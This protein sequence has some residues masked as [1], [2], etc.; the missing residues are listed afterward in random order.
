MGVYVGRMCCKCMACS[1]SCNKFQSE[2]WRKTAVVCQAAIMSETSFGKKKWHPGNRGMEGRSVHCSTPGP[3]GGRWDTASCSHIFLV[4]T[5]I[6]Q[7]SVLCLEASQPLCFP[8]FLIVGLGFFCVCGLAYSCPYFIKFERASS[9]HV[10]LRHKY[11][12][13]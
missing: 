10:I 5:Y 4:I 9:K 7:S 13:L 6:P 12:R 11:Y 2:S 1:G 8:G 3:R